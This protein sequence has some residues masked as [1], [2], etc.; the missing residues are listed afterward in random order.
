[1]Q[2][3]ALAYDSRSRVRHSTD[4]IKFNNTCPATITG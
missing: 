1:V 4:A 3:G 2:V